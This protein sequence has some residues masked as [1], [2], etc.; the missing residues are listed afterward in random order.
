MKKH[1]F[2]WIDGLVILVVLVLLA[3]TCI[4][5]L[6]NDKTAV[7]AEESTFQYQLE[8]NGIRQISVDCLQVG[9]ILY[10][11]EG[12]A[13]VGTIIAI[14]VAPAETVIIQDDG[15]LVQ[16]TS[17]NRYDVV[18][19]LEAQGT[20]EAGY[21]QVGTYDIKVNQYS[22]YFTKYSIWSA[23]VISLD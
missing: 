2:T 20:K 18:L 16:G 22:T 14:D 6:F 11:N 23:T 19:T 1:K 5:F 7:T 21:Y 8:I 15:T 4:K 13:E 12:K 10:D 9:D 17:E 3:G